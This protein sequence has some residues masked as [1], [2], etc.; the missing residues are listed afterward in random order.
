LEFNRS[1]HELEV[2]SQK[3]WRLM[4]PERHDEARQ[5][6]KKTFVGEAET[7]FQ[8]LI[9]TAPK[10]IDQSPT[11]PLLDLLPTDIEWNARKSDD[12]DQ[13][14]TSGRRGRKRKAP[15]INPDNDGSASEGRTL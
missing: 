6:L 13:P 15:E 2:L 10:T 4:P 9:A 5:L 8:R 7:W 1:S 14:S 11:S 3:L 12:S